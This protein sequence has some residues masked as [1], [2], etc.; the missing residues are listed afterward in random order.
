V[1]KVAFHIPISSGSSQDF[2]HSTVLH[3]KVLASMK[4][5][6]CFERCTLFE[7]WSFRNYFI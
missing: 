2:Q 4:V 7:S 1:F 6:K 5:I 3:S